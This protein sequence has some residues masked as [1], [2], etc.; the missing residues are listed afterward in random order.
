MAYYDV[1]SDYGGN[2]KTK[3]E[4]PESSYGGEV[5]RQFLCDG[6]GGESSCDF[7]YSDWTENDDGTAVPTVLGPDGLEQVTRG[8]AWSDGH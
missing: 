6:S 1:V 7:G 8:Q 4:I 3:T 2:G 5:P